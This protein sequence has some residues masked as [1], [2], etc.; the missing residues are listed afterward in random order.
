MLLATDALSIERTL[1]S[2][3]LSSCKLSK[4]Q[5]S[6]FAYLQGSAELLLKFAKT[7]DAYAGKLLDQ[8][9]FRTWL[10]NNVSYFREMILDKGFV[11]MCQNL[12]EIQRTNFTLEWAEDIQLYI[13]TLDKIR[14]SYVIPSILKVGL[15]FIFRYIFR[16][17]RE[18][19]HKRVI[20]RMLSWLEYKE[21]TMTLSKKSQ[22]CYESLCNVKIIDT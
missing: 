14:G 6:E 18:I 13:L 4:F 20:Q 1:G 9:I 12:T 22:C 16:Q 15:Y 3:M 8:R 5:L 10:Q 11:G 17:F 21:H 2:V 7:Y 19:G